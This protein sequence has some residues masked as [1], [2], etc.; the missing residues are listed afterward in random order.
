MGDLVRFG[1]L[2]LGMGSVRAETATKT[3][4]AELTCVCSLDQK[5]AQE[6]AKKLEC[7]WTTNYEKMLD[8]QDI[9]VIGVLTSSGTHCDYAVQALQAGKH[10]FVT[11]PMDVR[12]AKCDA[13]I[14]AAERAGKV[15]AVDFGLRY[16]PVNHKIRMAVRSGTF[17]KILYSDLLMRWHRTQGYYDGGIPAGWRSRTATEGGS[18][19]NQGVHSIDLMQWILG[20]VSTVYGRMGTVGHDI[21]TEDQTMSLLTFKS[22]AWGLVHTTTCST[23]DLGTKW[24]VGG[25]GGSFVWSGNET[26]LWHSE[27]NPESSLDDF[28]VDPNLPDSIIADMVSAV[29]ERT[30]VQCDGHEGRKSVEIFEAVY[31]SSRTGQVI[32]LF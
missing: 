20:S 28:Q 7:D 23:P 6:W 19:A 3:P 32:E 18:I 9:D 15:L 2:G 21:E 25:S 14:E 17:G 16:N 10:T 4:G 31:E 30:P 12:L 26:P 24:E 22:G 29:T 27:A 5:Q 11:K 13:A 8:R 1:I